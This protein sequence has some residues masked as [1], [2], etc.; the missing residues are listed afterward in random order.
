MA[1]KTTNRAAKVTPNNY[2]PETMKAEYLLYVHNMETAKI[3]P[4]SLAAYTKL[5]RAALA[6]QQR[7]QLRKLSVE[8]GN[9]GDA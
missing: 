3:K 6:N 7:N 5:R 2:A 1:K 8:G 4:R 9:D